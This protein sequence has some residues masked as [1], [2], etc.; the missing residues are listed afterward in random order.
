VKSRRLLI[1]FPLLILLLISAGWFGLHFLV[2]SDTFRDWLSRR[3]SQ[4]IHADGK[5]EPLIWEGSTFRSAGFSATGGPHSKLRSL[6]VTNISAH[7]DWR[8]LLQGVLAIDL[9]TAD[10]VDAVAGKSRGVTPAKPGTPHP[11]SLGPMSSF[12]IDLRVERLYVPSANLHWQTTTGENGEFTETKL[13]ATRTMGDQ[14]DIVAVG[15]TVRHA[16]YPPLQVDRI[17]CSA[18]QD[19]ISI[20]DAKA[21]VAGGGDVAITGRISIAK[22]LSAQLTSDFSE[23]ELTPFLPEP[24]PIGG[25]I[26]G[27]LTYTG[28]FDRFEHGEVAGAVKINGATFDMTNVFPTLRKLA[29]FGGLNDVRLDSIDTHLKYKE[30]RLELSDFHATSGDQIRVEGSGAITPDRLDAELIVGLSPKILGWIPGAEE[31]VFVDQRD[32]LRWARVTISGSPARPK[33]DLT[34]RLIAAFRDKMTKEFNG[35]TKDAFKSLLDMFHR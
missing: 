14:W 5:F 28:D 6:Q 24:W 10:K 31:K 35:E 9:V 8:R 2:Q 26:S 30:Q 17:H 23:L 34:Q 22:E 25:R 29:K 21:S 33:E 18:N 4:S 7:I 11:V 13:T 27:Q 19:S 1:L 32:G 16:N 3:V 12:H 15:G 20:L